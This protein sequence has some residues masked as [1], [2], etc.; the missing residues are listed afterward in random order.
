MII[1]A[2][3]GV[4]K[5]HFYNTY[6]DEFKIHDSDSSL[7]SWIVKDGQKIRNPDF[8]KNYIEHLESLNPK[9]IILVSSH[10]EVRKALEEHGF[11]YYLVYPTKE[12]KEEYLQRYKDR[13]SPETFIQLLDKNWDIWLTQLERYSYVEC[14]KIPLFKGQYLNDVMD[15]IFDLDGR[16]HISDELRNEILLEMQNDLIRSRND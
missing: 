13:G 16:V 4:G 14:I 15:D 2:F 7:F 3:P 11:E 10:E 12:C 1:S 6:K 9:D 5:S 8:P